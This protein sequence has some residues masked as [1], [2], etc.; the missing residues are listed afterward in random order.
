MS[1]VDAQHLRLLEAILFAAADPVPER[2]LADRLPE[3][4][5]VGTLLEHLGAHYAGAALTWS[6]QDRPG[7][8]ARR[9]IWRNS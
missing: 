5:D 3:G 6:R 4:A 9:P 7:P 1:G 2:V 8:C